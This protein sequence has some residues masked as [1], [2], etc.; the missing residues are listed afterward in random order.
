MARDTS[1]VLTFLIFTLIS[2]LSSAMLLAMVLSKRVT[3]VMM[4]LLNDI[5]HPSCSLLG[6]KKI[7]YIYL[8]R[9]IYI[10]PFLLLIH[11]LTSF[12]SPC[13]LMKLDNYTKWVWSKLYIILFSMNITLHIEINCHFVYYPVLQNTLR[14]TL[15]FLP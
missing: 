11:L 7:L 5:S 4:V 12:L 3:D 13:P 1:M 9:Q 14:V 6:T 8:T 15:H 10:P 2:A